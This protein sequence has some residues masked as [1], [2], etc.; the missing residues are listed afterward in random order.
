MDTYDIIKNKNLGVIIDIRP[1]DFIAGGETGIRG[2]IL[3]ALGQFDVYLPDEESQADWDPGFFID[4]CACVSFSALNAVEILFNRAIAR[5]ILT[6]EQLNFLKANGYIDPATGKVNFSDRFT[7]KMSGTTINGNSLGAVGDSIRNDG[8]IPEKA[9]PMPSF[10]DL[11]DEAPANGPYISHQTER[12]NRYYAAIPADLIAKGKAFAAIFKQ[13]ITYQWLLVGTADNAKLIED[14]KAGPIQIA[15]AVCSPWSSNEGMPP[16]PAC[17]CNTQ[18]ATILYGSADAGVLKDFDHYKSFRKLLAAD[19][20]IQYAVQYYLNPDAGIEQP[21]QS[22]KGYTY[23]K[24]L[25]AGA[26]DTFDVRMLQAGLQYAKDANNTPYMKP[27]V[28]GPF[29]PATK[30]ALGRFQTAKGIK[31]PDGQGTNFGPASRAAL[32]LAV[33]K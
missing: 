27:G 11:Q 19:Y 10:A 1:R 6:T 32:T 30:L 3:E 5:G 26:P 24:N 14:L 23:T 17:G 22:P 21:P 8:L 12:F 9:W 33:S 18:H 15:A 4:T 20:C 25:R 13:T 2:A 16:I 31:D 28:F 29:G 7:A